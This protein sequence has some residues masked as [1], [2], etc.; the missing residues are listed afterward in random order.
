MFDAGDH[1]GATQPVCFVEIGDRPARR[2]IGMGVVKT[3]DVQALLPCLT[4]NADQFL[5][6]NVVAIMGG[7]GPRIACTDGYLYLVDPIERLAEQHSATLMGI[8]LFAMLAQL[9]IN[10]FTDLQLLPQ[11]RRGHHC[12]QNRSLRYLSAESHRMVTRTALLPERA[13]SSAI[14]RLAATAAAAEMP[15]SSPSFRPRCLA[16]S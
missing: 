8:G 14:L 7:I 11:A 4:L 2:M 13:S 10:R 6:G 5:G 3:H 15:S 12:S 1:V 16:I 9:A